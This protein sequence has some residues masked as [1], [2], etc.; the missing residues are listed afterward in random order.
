[1]SEL[2]RGERRWDSINYS[3]AP[4]RDTFTGISEG[5][6]PSSGSFARDERNT[7][8]Y[9]AANVPDSNF[10]ERARIWIRNRPAVGFFGNSANYVTVVGLFPLIHGGAK[11]NIRDA[12][13]TPFF[14]V[15]FA[16]TLARATSA[17]KSCLIM[18]N[19]PEI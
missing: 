2:S 17:G 3:N 11:Y 9:L 10:R 16:N 14:F 7:T 19:K 1:M 15:V 6:L 8:G 4:C 13:A 5:R 12:K 18:T